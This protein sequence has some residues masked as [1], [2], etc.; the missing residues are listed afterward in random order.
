VRVGK[1]SFDGAGKLARVTYETAVA[2]SAAADL[3]PLNCVTKRTRTIVVEPY[4]G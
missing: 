4:P 3:A 1:Q 2:K